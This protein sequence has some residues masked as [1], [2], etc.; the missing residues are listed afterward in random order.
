M[1]SA[2][3]TDE[4]SA[5]QETAR[6]TCKRNEKRSAA[7][8]RPLDWQTGKLSRRTAH[9]CRRVRVSRTRR[10]GRVDRR[11]AARCRLDDDCIGRPPTAGNINR[12]ARAR[13][14]PV[15]RRHRRSRTRAYGFSELFRPKRLRRRTPTDISR[16]IDPNSLQNYREYIKLKKKKM[17]IKIVNSKGVTNNHRKILQK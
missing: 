13:L 6:A 9:Y 11:T 15:V 2:N 1:A 10:D 3:V 8:A 4:T 5:R 14:C 12:Y 7:R 17:K 16:T